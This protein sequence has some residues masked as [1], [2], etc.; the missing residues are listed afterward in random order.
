[1]R[2]EVNGLDGDCGPVMDGMTACVS[3][4]L[5]LPSPRTVAQ[6]K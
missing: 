5:S 1:M 6:G 4:C 2:N 3:S